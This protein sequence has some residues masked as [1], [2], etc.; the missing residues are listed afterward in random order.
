M[1]RWRETSLCAQQCSHCEL[2]RALIAEG[3]MRSLLVVPSD[4]TAYL[5]A[6]L[7]ERLEV[8]LPHALLF[9]TTEGILG[10]SQEAIFPLLDLGDG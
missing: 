7:P 3:L 8:V 2:R 10:T 4:P 9:Q 1:C 5:L 6:R